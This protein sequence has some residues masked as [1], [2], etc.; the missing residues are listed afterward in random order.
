MGRVRGKTA[1]ELGLSA[2]GLSGFHFYFV[3]WSVELSVIGFALFPNT[4]TR[5]VFV[6]QDFT[7]EVRYM[8]Q[9]WR[10]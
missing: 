2:E 9:H 4:T 3:G 7:Y 8:Q 5:N 10:H 1:V 6:A